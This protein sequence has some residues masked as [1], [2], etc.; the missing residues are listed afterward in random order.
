[1]E[2]QENG[3]I[4][5]IPTPN[6]VWAYD[7]PCHSDFW[8]SLGHQQSYNSDYDS[9]SIVSENQPLGRY[10]YINTPGMVQVQSHMVAFPTQDLKVLFS[11]ARVLK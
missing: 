10:M 11:A 3:K 9:N 1:M 5:I 8:L 7:F 6:F 2:S 4:M